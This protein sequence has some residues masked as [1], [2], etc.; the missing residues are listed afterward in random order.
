MAHILVI[1]NE[2]A[3]SKTLLDA[4]LAEAGG[5]DRVTVIAPVNEPNQG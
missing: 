3:A 2:T 5:Q 1:A 4:V